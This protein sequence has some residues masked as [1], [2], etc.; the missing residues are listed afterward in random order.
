MEGQRLLR[1]GDLFIK[2]QKPHQ[3]QKVWAQNVQLQVWF[4][5]LFFGRGRGLATAQSKVA[6]KPEVNE[7][8]LWLTN[9]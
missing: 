3:E 2:G 5:F 7:Q 9:I 8:K 4:L 1:R 6:H